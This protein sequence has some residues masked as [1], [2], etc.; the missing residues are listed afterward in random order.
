MASLSDPELVAV[1]SVGRPALEAV[2]PGLPEAACAA[3]VFH[4]PQCGHWPCHFG[5]WP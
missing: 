1:T 4:S 2:L 3:R 5:D